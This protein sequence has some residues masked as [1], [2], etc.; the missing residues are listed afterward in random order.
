M[1]IRADLCI[2]LT[3]W[4]TVSGGLSPAYWPIPQERW[5][6]LMS[7]ERISDRDFVDQRVRV[8]D[9]WIIC[10]PKTLEELT[11]ELEHAA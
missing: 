10:K 5:N 2:E 11:K 8:L 3:K 7:E 4:F 1:G 9:T 6:V